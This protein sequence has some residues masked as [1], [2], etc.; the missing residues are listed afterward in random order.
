[1]PDTAVVSVLYRGSNVIV[2]L[3][4]RELKN[5]YLAGDLLE[6][7]EKLSLGEREKLAELAVRK[8]ERQGRR[9]GK[10]RVFDAK[11]TRQEDHGN[12]E[13]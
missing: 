5:A 2:R 4:G 6:V 13:D 1:M 7:T 11:E 9:P 12:L 3:D 8:L 10:R